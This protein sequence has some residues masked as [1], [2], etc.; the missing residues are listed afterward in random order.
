M[1]HKAYESE[2]NEFEPRLKST[3]NGFQL[4][5]RFNLETL[6][7]IFDVEPTIFE[8]RLKFKPRLKFFKFGLWVSKTGFPSLHAWRG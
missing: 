3:K 8:P 1:F 7:T 5:D 2:F 6:I 4:S